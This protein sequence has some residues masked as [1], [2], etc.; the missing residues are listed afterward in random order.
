ME[1][2]TFRVETTSKIL[3]T[4]IQKISNLSFFPDSANYGQSFLTKTYSKRAA[5]KFISALKIF[6]QFFSRILTFFGNHYFINVYS[7]FRRCFT[8]YI[9]FWETR[10]WFKIFKYTLNQT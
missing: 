7:V 2:C 1:T 3:P 9:C 5:E 4:G 10:E 8:T 6:V